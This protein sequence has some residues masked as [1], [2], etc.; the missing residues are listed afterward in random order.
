[1]PRMSMLNS[2]FY[3]IFYV[4]KKCSKHKELLTSLIILIKYIK[5]I[6]GYYYS[7]LYLCVTLLFLYLS[8]AYINNNHVYGPRLIRD[9]HLD[10]CE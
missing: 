10:E 5:I 1:M 4:F 7:M 2:L 6:Y 8:I 9:L 3:E